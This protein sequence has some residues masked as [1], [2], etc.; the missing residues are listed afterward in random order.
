[1]F[2]SEVADLVKIENATDED[3]YTDETEVSRVKN[4]FINVKSVKRA[5]FYAARQAGVDMAMTFEVRTADYTG[6]NIVEYKQPG[7]KKPT[8]YRVIRTYTEGGDIIELNCA[9]A[10]LPA[11]VGRSRRGT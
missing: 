8:A 6:E 4:V 1:M 9:L 2:W 3:G 5:E 11:S 7:H 10:T